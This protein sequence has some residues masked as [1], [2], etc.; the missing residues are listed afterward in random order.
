[1][2]LSGLILG[3]CIE[4]IGCDCRKFLI[5]ALYL[6]S[7]LAYTRNDDFIVHNG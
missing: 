2:N 5:I 1:M 4:E 7:L 6:I 3:G